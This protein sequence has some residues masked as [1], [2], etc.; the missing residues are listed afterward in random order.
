M[1][2][3]SLYTYTPP[4]LFSSIRRE[5]ETPFQDS[6]KPAATK[7]TPA[8]AASPSGEGW[9]CVQVPLSVHSPL[10]AFPRSYN[11]NGFM[12]YCKPTVVQ[13]D[14]D[15]SRK[16]PMQRVQSVR[17]RS[18]RSMAILPFDGVRVMETFLQTAFASDPFEITFLVGSFART[19]TMWKLQCRHSGHLPRGV[20]SKIPLYLVLSDF[21]E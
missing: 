8:R 15:R 1:F 11:T 6:N 4:T 14:C 2:P 18:C 10:K 7:K 5:E 3:P 12:P 20:A 21:T 17:W 16:R 19:R 13:S 9:P